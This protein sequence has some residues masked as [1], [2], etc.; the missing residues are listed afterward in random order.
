MISFWDAQQGDLEPVTRK[1]DAGAL[2]PDGEGGA[3]AIAEAAASGDERAQTIWDECCRAIAV[4]C[5]NLEHALG[6]EKILLGGG[7]GEAGRMLLEPVRAEFDRRRWQMTAD[8][9]AIE[10]AALGEYA[11]AIGA[12]GWFMYHFERGLV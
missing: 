5:V 7:I 3:Q 8:R 1:I 12:G 9:P 6:P 10:A 4:A 2:S 11:G